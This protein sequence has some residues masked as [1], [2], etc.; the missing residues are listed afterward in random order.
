MANADHI[1]NSPIMENA[2][3][4]ENR[5]RDLPFTQPQIV[6]NPQ[7]TSSWTEQSSNAVSTPV[8]AVGNGEYM[9]QDDFN[10]LTPATQAQIKQIGVTAY[11]DLA[12]AQNAEIQKNYTKLDDG[13]YVSTDYF[14]KL[15]LDDRTQLKTGGVDAFNKAQ[16]QNAANYEQSFKDSH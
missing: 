16:A 11:N 9:S 14:N 3:L 10:N 8:V 7:V 1:T 15:S 6:Q 13:S 12:K 4:I 5:K 2:Q